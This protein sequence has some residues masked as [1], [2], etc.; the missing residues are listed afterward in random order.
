MA[1]YILD[2]IAG[3]VGT[4]PEERTTPSGDKVL[5]FSVAQPQK[6]GKEAPEPFWFQVAVWD[7][8]LRG[9]VKQQIKKGKPVVI[10][11]RRKPDRQHNGKTYRDF[12]AYRI[13]IAEY[14]FPLDRAPGQ[15]AQESQP[16]QAPDADDELPF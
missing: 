3:N 2:V 9:L 11:G 1:D 16:R 7:A 10:F 14:L 15:P 12:T 8:P 6:F 13:G 5:S 4:N